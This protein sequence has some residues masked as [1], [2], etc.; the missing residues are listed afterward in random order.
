MDLRPD[1]PPAFATA[2]DRCRGRPR[3]C[4]TGLDR[5]VP[6]LDDLRD[7]SARNRQRAGRL[8]GGG[9]AGERSRQ[10]DRPGQCAAEHPEVRHRQARI[11]Q[12]PLGHDREDSA[13]DRPR[14]G[15]FA[16]R[17]L[18][19]R[20]PGLRPAARWQPGRPAA[21]AADRRERAGAARRHRQHRPPGPSSGQ[22]HDRWSRR[23]SQ[24]RLPVPE[25]RRAGWSPT[26]GAAGQRPCSF[27]R[28]RSSGPRAHWR[29]RARTSSGPRST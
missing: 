5:L 10:G 14:P 22:G 1:R 27:P 19:D 2:R 28:R 20:L 3:G 11:D 29:R 6:L 24:C 4:P 23:A 26:A 15:P 18:R 7:D 13:E 17:E 9:P 21:R 8:A 25:G 16:A 12:R